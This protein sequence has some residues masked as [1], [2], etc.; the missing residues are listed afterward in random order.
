[1]ILFDTMFCH[2][3]KFQNCHD[4]TFDHLRDKLFRRHHRPTRGVTQ[5]NPKVPLSEN[6][7]LQQWCVHAQRAFRPDKS[8]FGYCL[9]GCRPPDHRR[10]MVSQVN[11]SAYMMAGRREL[12]GHASPQRKAG[13]SH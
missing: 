4:P 1:M 9:Q 6:R 2:L 10:L 12:V 13:L 8:G 3:H 5:K 11:L 7:Q